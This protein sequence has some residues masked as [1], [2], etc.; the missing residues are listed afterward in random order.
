MFL[1][2]IGGSDGIAA[3]IMNLSLNS[4]QCSDFQDHEPTNELDKNIN[5]WMMTEF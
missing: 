3:L 4:A 1:R 2:N 5:S